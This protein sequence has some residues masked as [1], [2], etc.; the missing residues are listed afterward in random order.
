M[1]TLIT[2]HP[3][4]SR[5]QYRYVVYCVRDDGKDVSNPELDESGDYIIA[6]NGIM[7]GLSYNDIQIENLFRKCSAAAII[8][9]VCLTLFVKK[10]RENRDKKGGIEYD[11]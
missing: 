1:V 11:L 3:Y 9:V 6:S 4:R 8:C 10:R 5:G 2:C 7:Y